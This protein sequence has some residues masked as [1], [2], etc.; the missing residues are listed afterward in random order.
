MTNEL[1]RLVYYSMVTIDGDEALVDSEIN[2]ILT[3]SRVNNPRVGVTGAL[4]FNSGCFGQI[5]EGPLAAVEETFERIQQDER[6]SE[7]TLLAFD[8][9]PDRAFPSW[10]MGHV[11]KSLRDADRFD[12][13]GLDTGFDLTRMTGAALFETL[14][15]LAIEEER[16]TA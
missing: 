3:A 9:V 7:V 10:S 8:Q 2:S 5:L 11:G 6:H 14:V 1:Y 15:Q 13:V 12:K 4:M 16:V